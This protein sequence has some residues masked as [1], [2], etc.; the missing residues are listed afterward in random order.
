MS[1]PTQQAPTPQPTLPTFPTPPYTPHHGYTAGGLLM[2]IAALGT[3]GAI[4]GYITH[5][6]ASHFYFIILFPLLIGLAIGAIG[7][8]MVKV[9]RLRNPWLGGLAGFLAG[10][11]AMTSMHYFDYEEFRSQL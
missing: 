6:I 1:D 3:I 9:G 11:F 7:S 4:L 8:R 2:L 10:V 5:L